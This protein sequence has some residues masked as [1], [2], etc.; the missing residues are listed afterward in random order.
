MPANWKECLPDVSCWQPI[1]RN[2]D[3]L[4]NALEITC[5]LAQH[6]ITS[7]TKAEV[8]FNIYNYDSGYGVEDV[9]REELSNLLPERYSVE[10][11]VVDDRHGKTAG[12]C[13]LIVRDRMWSP[14]IKLGAT[15]KSRRFHFPIEGVYAAAEI[16]QTL[17][18]A[19][20]DAAM[21]KLVTISRLDRPDNP[22]GHITENQHLQFFDKPGQI[23]NPLHT[24]V[25]ATGLK[26][27][28]TF[29]DIAQRFGS[30]NA[31][32]TRDTMVKMLCVLDRG[33]AWYSVESGSPYNA[34]YMTDRCQPL[35]LQVNSR[36]PQ[37]AF[38]RFYIELLGH[39]TRSVL[40]LA[41][42]KYGNPPPPRY[43]V[44]YGTAVFN[45]DIHPLPPNPDN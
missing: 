29:N 40:G 23:L 27:G 16:K 39:L 26:D 44:K 20:L 38:Y 2:D 36:E 8:R 35:L 22:Y 45:A 3:T 15:S 42:L 11:G 41:G 43:V 13:D 21:K 25:F 33:T 7:R 1:Q 24:S 4:K 37:S 14:V 17:G 5:Q 34:T 10:P 19:E 31:M 30:I 12:D 9:V 28:I 32:L 6:R 18:F